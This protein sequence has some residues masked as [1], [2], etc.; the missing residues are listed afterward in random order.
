MRT[1]VTQFPRYLVRSAGNAATSEPLFKF[2]E[3]I[4]TQVG[5]VLRYDRLQSRC[6]SNHYISFV[7][8]RN[9]KQGTLIFGPSD[10]AS[11]VFWNYSGT[12]LSP[13]TE[14]PSGLYI[15]YTAELQ[16]A[17][18]ALFYVYKTEP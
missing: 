7:L 10:I 18:V 1:E 14:C 3:H 11:A 8:Q 6:D 12:R 17:F 9:R 13:V 16:E 2:L 15:V 4:T 5:H